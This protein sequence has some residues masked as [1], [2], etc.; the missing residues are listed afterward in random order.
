M[1]EVPL[2]P[3]F[4]QPEEAFEAAAKQVHYDGIDSLNR[5]L[6]TLTE[7]APGLHLYLMRFIKDVVQPLNPD[8]EIFGKDEGEATEE[9]IRHANLNVHAFMTG[10]V[11]AF[12]MID[13]VSWDTHTEVPLT[14]GNVRRICLEVPAIDLESDTPVIDIEY[15]GREFSTDLPHVYRPTLLLSRQ[16]LYDNPETVGIDM[17]EEDLTGAAQDHSEGPHEAIR[18]LHFVAGAAEVALT[19]EEFA[20]ALAIEQERRGHV[21]WE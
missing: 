9:E 18:H 13:G 19:I 20:Y 6:G 1:A 3:V 4:R 10:T 7:R 15:R 12:S 14:P 2:A 8:A 16:L 11:M 5:M 17:V 21:E